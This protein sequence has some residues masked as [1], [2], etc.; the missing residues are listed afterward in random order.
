MEME[1]NEIN[2]N[3]KYVGVVLSPLL[4]YVTKYP[5]QP[6]PEKTVEMTEERGKKR[7]VS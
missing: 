4:R 2:K 6:R 1:I 5:A 3:T 7:L